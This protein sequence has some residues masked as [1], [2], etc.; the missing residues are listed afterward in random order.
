[1]IGSRGAGC[2]ASTRRLVERE[3]T[4]STFVEARLERTGETRDR[5]TLAA[6]YGAYVEMCGDGKAPEKKAVF[7][8]ALLGALG[9]FA[10]PYQGQ[11]NHWHGWKLRSDSDDGEDAE[12]STP[13][14]PRVERETDGLEGN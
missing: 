6:A 7:K 3:S 11:R 14:P 12:S 10:P 13:P 5:V 2:A 9:P 1:M 8:D 4:V